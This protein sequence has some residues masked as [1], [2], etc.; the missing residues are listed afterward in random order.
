MKPYLHWLCD[1]E[2]TRQL[3]AHELRVLMP[4]LARAVGMTPVGPT[5]VAF[6]GKRLWQR[7]WLKRSPG[8]PW[9]LSAVQPVAES[10]CI[11]HY[12]AP[13]H[14]AVDIF[15]CKQLDPVVAKRILL[16]HFQIRNIYSETTLE[17]GPELA[18]MD[19]VIGTHH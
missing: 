7:L 8:H 9:G 6:Q 2:Y 4:F 14:V 17:R 12:M 16:T 18:E 15:V 3:T 13:P 10:H 19:G 5:M 11:L 1:A